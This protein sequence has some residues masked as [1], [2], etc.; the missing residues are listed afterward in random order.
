M[1]EVSS[2]SG[3]LGR[4]LAVGID[5]RNRRQDLESLP[6]L[7]E[8]FRQQQIQTD[9]L[10]VVADDEDNILRV[11]SLD[12]PG[13]PLAEFPMGRFLKTNVQKHPEADIE[14][15]YT[16]GP[17]LAMV[18]SDKGITNLHVPSDIIID[19]SMPAMSP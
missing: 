8:D 7:I 14:A 18:N 17:A 19:A 15:C 13:M 9:V 4:G 5:A 6:Q 3:Q 10:F 16:E 2:G 12:A 11:Y 1:E